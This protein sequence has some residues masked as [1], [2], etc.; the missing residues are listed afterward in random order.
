MSPRTTD[1]SEIPVGGILFAAATAQQDNEAN[2]HHSEEGGSCSQV[3]T[4]TL[5]RRFRV[6]RITT[7]ANLSAEN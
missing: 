6:R 2:H 5:A 1:R 7:T 3:T 4:I